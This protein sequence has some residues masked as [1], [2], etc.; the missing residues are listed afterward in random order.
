MNRLKLIKLSCIVPVMSCDT[1]N[2]STEVPSQQSL[3]ILAGQVEKP[4]YQCV[5]DGCVR[6]YTSMGN[7]KVHMKAH[8]KKFDFKCDVEGCDK[9]FVSSYSLKIHRRV[10]TGEKPY[11]CPETYCDKT[12]NTKYRLNAHRRIHSGD[13]FDCEYNDCGKQFTTRSD[14]KK[15]IRKH[16]GER[17]YQCIVDGCGKTFAAS[18]HLK[19]HTQSHDS[20][21]WECSEEGCPTKFK[22]R[23][24]FVSHLLLTHNKV[25]PTEGTDDSTLDDVSRTMDGQNSS[26]DCPNTFSSSI[27]SFS[28]D[29][30]RTEP[31]GM[32]SH[33]PSSSGSVAGV[34]T[35][36]STVETP[37]VGEVAQAL[38][39]LQ[40]FFNGFSSNTIR[41][42]PESMLA[43]PIISNVK[44]SLSSLPHQETNPPLPPPPPAFGG[45]LSESDNYMQNSA[46]ETE[47]DHLLDIF[48]NGANNITLSTLPVQEPNPSPPPHSPPPALGG[49]FS[50]SDNYIQNS[51]TKPESDHLLDIFK[52]GADSITAEPM[53]STCFDLDAS[54]NISTQ[55][56]PIDID[57]SLLDPSFFDSIGSEFPLDNSGPAGMLDATTMGMVWDNA[58]EFVGQNVTMHPPSY[59]VEPST[60][61]SINFPVTQSSSGTKRDQ[62]CQTEILPASCCNWKSEATGGSCESENC[63]KC[64]QC[65]SSDCGCCSH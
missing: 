40:K 10:H 30:S 43:L 58:V 59:E 62:M 11:M 14:L 2:M 18:H 8:K 65:S 27:Q 57:L 52:D 37:S 61:Q 3:S 16:T 35:S 50:Q 13:T 46:T 21:G 36:L 29:A 28:L 38:N 23:E 56:P 24:E 7:L 6:K 15:H 32:E 4:L 31:F 48:K 25:F 5:Y 47:P 41:E 1:L 17:P 45:H 12:F 26:L 44:S 9:A 49:H 34:P 42:L 20:S 63:C 55:T 51:A 64:C 53:V 54:M 19:S 33:T 60:S 39:T 22:N